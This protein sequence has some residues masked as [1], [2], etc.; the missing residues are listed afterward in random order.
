MTSSEQRPSPGLVAAV[1][2]AALVAV[3]LVQFFTAHTT[4]LTPWKGGGFGM[5]STVDVASGRMVMVYLEFDGEEYPAA[6]PEQVDD[7]LQSLRPMP[8]EERT[9]EFAR[10]LAS[11]SWVELEKHEPVAL[12]QFGDRAESVSGRHW[13]VREPLHDRADV[14]EPDG[15]RVQ[16]W[17]RT[18][19]ADDDGGGILTPVKIQDVHVPSFE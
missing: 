12:Q 10:R 11:I 14:V 13:V 16:V 9:E 6:I 19:E 17:S 18:F 3:F 4:V 15:V 7:D 5:F 2:L 1:P 8:T